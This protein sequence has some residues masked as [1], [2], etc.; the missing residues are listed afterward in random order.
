M[1]KPSWSFVLSHFPVRAPH[2]ASNPSLTVSTLLSWARGGHMLHFKHVNCMAW[3]EWSCSAHTVNHKSQV[4]GRILEICVCDCT[5]H[6]SYWRSPTWASV[7]H[8]WHP[9]VHEQVLGC[10]NS[11][12]SGFCQSIF[13]SN[14]N[15]TIYFS[16]LFPCTAWSFSRFKG[17]CKSAVAGTW[18]CCYSCYW[19]ASTNASSIT[20]SH[21]WQK[22]AS[23]DKFS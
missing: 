21:H 22:E 20:P 5:M 2:Q 14:D 13:L 8:S 18:W 6:C 17:T 7:T 4:F 12:D 16:I 11:E 23:L 9:L 3:H 10:F 1:P 15:L 19:Q